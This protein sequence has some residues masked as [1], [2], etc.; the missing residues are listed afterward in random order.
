MLVEERERSWSQFFAAVSPLRFAAALV[1][2]AAMGVG[3]GW[4][5]AEIGVSAATLVAIGISVLGLALAQLGLAR[6]ARRERAEFEGQILA[7]ERAELELA[8]HEV[9][10]IQ[11]ILGTEKSPV[12][13]V[14]EIAAEAAGWRGRALGRSVGREGQRVSETER[15]AF[16]D[17]GLDPGW[18]EHGASIR[19]VGETRGF[20]LLL[21][22]LPASGK[23]TIARGLEA[24]FRER[25]VAVEV[26][27]E[28]FLRRAVSQELGYSK[29][30]RDQGLMRTAFFA[31]L[32]ARQGVAVIVADTAPYEEIRRAMRTLFED[33]YIEAY[34]KADVDTASERDPEGL[35]R[36]AFAGEISEFTGVSDPYEIPEEPELVLDT[37][38][39]D[40]AA[41]VGQAIAFLEAKRFLAQPSSEYT[42]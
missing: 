21:T 18:V 39:E 10:E 20:V 35:Y 3:I 17:L 38:A 36:K 34:V 12:Q 25:G 19:G 33:R 4:L 27:D 13:A 14:S 37:E 6:A 16:E 40:A 7:K 30:D 22:G 26:L 1:V 42:Y 5:F 2:L 15:R 31:L 9:A 8:R 28:G 41:L 23:T 11:Q 32:L 24:A 29:A